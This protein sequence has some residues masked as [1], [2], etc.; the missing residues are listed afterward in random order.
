MA[1]ALLERIQNNMRTQQLN[2]GIGTLNE[3]TLHG[4]LKNLF[5]PETTKQEIKIGRYIADIADGNQITE[6]QTRDFSKFRKKLECFLDMGKEVCVVYPVSFIKWLIW[7]DEESGECSKKRKS[8]KPGTPYTILQELYKIKY[9]LTRPKL[10]FCIVM[11]EME[12]Y[13]VLNGW[14]EDK[15]KGSSRCTRIPIK[16][17]DIITLSTVQDYQQLVPYTLAEPFT[18]KQYQEHT[19]LSLSRSQTALNVLYSIGV[20]QRVGK[21]GRAFLYARQN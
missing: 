7:I 17:Y 2:K 19:R 13:R 21:K 15:K 18:A 8:P 16:I 1:Q 4:V 20:L 3:H 10:S 6:I 14:S 11:L 9:L 5:E 12:E